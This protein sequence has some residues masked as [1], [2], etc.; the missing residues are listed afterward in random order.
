MA[1]EVH[2]P[3][4]RVRPFLIV[5]AVGILLMFSWNVISLVADWLWFVEVG[6]HNV[7]TTTFTAKIASFLIFGIA[8]FIIFFGNLFLVNRLTSKLVV[9]DRDDQFQ[10]PPFLAERRATLKVILILSAVFSILAAQVG[11]AQ[12][13]SLLLFLY[14]LPFGIKDPL[15][16]KDI[17]FYVFSMPFLRYVHG[18][19]VF[20]VIM[21]AV[22][23]AVFY[24]MRRSFQFTPPRTFRAAPEA[25]IHMACLAAALFLISAFGS[26]L[27]LY[28]LLFEKTGVVFGPGYTLATT[29]IWAIYAL[30]ITYILGGAAF[31]VYA[32]R[33]NWRI[34]AAAVLVIVL[35]TVIGRGIYPS[36]IQTYKVVPNEVVLER[37][38]LEHNIKYTRIAY[39]I[40]SVEEQEFAAEESLTR[41]DLRR[42]ELTIKNIRLWN[43]APLLSTYSQ[44][45]E[46]RTYY[47]FGDVDNDRYVINGEYRQTMLSPREISYEALP[48]RSWV[49]EHLTYTHGYGAV[50]SPVNRVTSEGLP[51]FFIKDIPPV[52]SINIKVT[53]PEIYFGE[54][55]NEYVI[56]GAK[57]PEFD[58]PVG[59][60]NVYSRYEGQGGVPLSFWKK[61]LFA[62]RFGAFNILL[63]T[64]IGPGSRI[65]YNRNI[66]ER[67]MLVAPFLRLDNDPYMVITD[68]GRLVW[69]IDGYTV[70]GRFPYSEPAGRFGNYIRNSV[71]AA[72]D[73]YD[74][75]VK[76]YI[77]DPADPIIRTYSAIFPGTFFKFED[78]PADLLAHSRY[79]EG[80]FA[81]QTRMYRAY[82]MQDPQVF[83]NKED[84]WAIPSVS[85]T[86]G[87]EHE[88]EPYYTIMRI[89]GQKKEEYIL[90]LPFTP[91]KRDN[92]SAWMAARCD[93]PNY[94]KL[95][96]YVFPKQR[97]VYGP[98]QIEARINQDTYISQQLSL[99]NQR[100]SQV[101][102][103]GMLAIPIE[104]SILYVGP[105]FLAAEKGQLPE[106]KRVIV[107]YG[108][109]IVMDETLDGALQRVFGGASPLAKPDR[110]EPAAMPGAPKS[111]KAIA[112]E[113][114]SH[115]RKAQ[116]YLKQGNWAAYGEEMNRVSAILKSAEKQP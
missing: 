2:P 58:Y 90:L 9:I 53:R 46:I 25:R 5:L 108:N 4:R 55:S 80:L 93:A 111:D 14:G 3:V 40:D 16:A 102:K 109:S 96:V 50:L 64:D 72:V 83:Y 18:F 104:R 48:S 15:F 32:F 42:N 87:Q 76:L 20:S 78:M 97:L 85:Q 81:I 56:V 113:A 70:T 94:G 106:L 60:K 63:S 31:I 47:K 54:K 12:W 24:T 51:D 13:E 99:W 74:G 7:F 112:L 41:Q 95:V 67:V 59:D 101:I 19:A 107:A 26:W 89:P 22:V 27:D 44:L 61:L 52:S 30:I 116:E 38:Y 62:G 103:G 68:S 11:V 98:R 45:Q 75:S 115:F 105:L 69:I 110:A 39:G 8:F 71:K 28:D 43:H 84:L 33:P 86:G 37:P 35:I 77:S 66:K 88:M 21:T 10:V 36:F 73:A 49:N 6:Y 79:P 65:M 57:G 82:H 114:L 91:S 92:L 100:G 1:F 23:T 29:Q 17:G 34:P